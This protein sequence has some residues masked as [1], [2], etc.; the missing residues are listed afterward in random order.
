MVTAGI[1]SV[2]IGSHFGGGDHFAGGTCPYRHCLPE[3]AQSSQAQHVPGD[4]P[5]SCR[6]VCCRL[7]DHLVFL[8]GKEIQI[9]DH[10]LL[11]CPSVIGFHVWYRLILLASVTNLA[12]ISLE[13]MHATFRPFKHRLIKK[14]M[15]E[16]AIAAVWITAGLCS[17]IAV[18]DVIPSV[19]IGELNRVFFTLYSSFF[20][21]FLVIPLFSYTSIAIKIVCENQPRH[22]GATSGERKLTKTVFIVTAAFLL[23]TLPFII[24]RMFRIYITH[25]KNHFNSNVFSVA[26][27]FRLVIFAN[28]LVN[29]FLYTLRIPEF[30]RALFSFLCC[31]S[32][33]QRFQVFPL[34]DK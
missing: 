18:S 27:I 17:A 33:P 4:Q 25:F 13:R 11:N 22:H 12:P 16:A 6:H 10:Q 26:S 15:F 28:S 32:E 31:R 2:V 29:P 34:N 24:F 3:R 5:G 21:F 1:I 9:L 23:L 19:T 8:L 30:K 7:C 14:K 20:L